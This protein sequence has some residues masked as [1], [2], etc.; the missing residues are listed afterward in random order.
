MSETSAE[1]RRLNLM[2]ALSATR[3]RLTREQIRDRVEGYDAVPAGATAQE[4][5]RAD[6]SFQRM[7]ER[8]KDELRRM[9]I[10]L[11]TITDPT[12]Q[13]DLGYRIDGDMAMPELDLSLQDAAVL[14]LAVEYWSGRSMAADARQGYAKLI[15]SVAHG[16][17]PRLPYG[18]MSTTVGVEATATLSEAITERQS[19]R[20]EYASASSD[21]RVRTVQP[22]TIVMRAGLEYLVGWDVDAEDSRVFRLG[23]ILGTVRLVGEPEA[24]ERPATV[25]LGS[26]A[27]E[28]EVSTAVV[29]V[30]PEA[31]HAVRRRGRP[32][33]A[34]DGWELFEV[35]YRHADVLRSEVLSMNGAA[36]I[37]S[38]ESLATSVIEHARAALEVARG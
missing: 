1:Q 5:Q 15:S 9:G 34:R 30:R 35:D 37:V 28:A 20:F 25:S 4:R 24:F 16:Q 7:F 8:D 13:N 6:A 26:L 2:I 32:A 19:V 3:H 31:G 11:R 10:P 33:G 38:P 17:G 29:A 21:T 22:W 18:G 14:A 27:D 12:H 36:R 23:R